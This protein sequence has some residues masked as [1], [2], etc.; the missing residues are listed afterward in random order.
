MGQ[1]QPTSDHDEQPELER[2]QP[3]PSQQSR[4]LDWRPQVF[5]SSKGESENAVPPVRRVPRPGPRRRPPTEGAPAWVV[6]LGVGALIAVIILLVLAFV[7]SRRSAEPEP[8]PTVVVVTP[9]VTLAPRPTAT[10]PQAATATSTD[11]TEETSPTAPAADT[12]AVGGYVRVAADAG[13]SFRQ[14][15]STSG[16]LIQVL[17]SGT[18]LEVIGGPREADGYT[19]W[20]LRTLDDG[21]EGWS[22]AGTADDVFLEPSAAP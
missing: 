9:T 13:L 19:W 7:F 5:R 4:R 18:T 12:I 11:A 10:P 14:N 16:A 17:D 15:P 2:T 1:E 8:T 3:S 21:N 6:G 22:A 20:Q